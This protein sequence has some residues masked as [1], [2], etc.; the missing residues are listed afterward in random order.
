MCFLP[1]VLRAETNGAGRMIFIQN[2][3]I[4]ILWYVL[5]LIEA[6][7][8]SYDVQSDMN[9]PGYRVTD[10]ESKQELKITGI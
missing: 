9:V 3:Q 5:Q 7:S 2:P 6:T 1:K 10:K 4:T 8:D